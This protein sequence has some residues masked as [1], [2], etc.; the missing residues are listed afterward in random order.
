[1]AG[2]IIKINK[3][4]QGPARVHLQTTIKGAAGLLK[5]ILI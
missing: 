5:E 4:A 3:A 1:V 2:G